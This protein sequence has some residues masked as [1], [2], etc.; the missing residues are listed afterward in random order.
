MKLPRS[1]AG[2]KASG[3]RL[4]RLVPRAVEGDWDEAARSDTLHPTHGYVDAFVMDRELQD[5]T[6]RLVLRRVRRWQP[7]LSRITALV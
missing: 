7:R 5:T 1:I 6:S 4:V 2:A 3:G